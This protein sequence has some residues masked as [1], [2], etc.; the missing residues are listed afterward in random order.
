M[1]RDKVFK[2]IG[3]DR[4]NL[5]E[6]Q[7]KQLV[8]NNIVDVYGEIIKKGFRE[9]IKKVDIE[10]YFSP[11]NIAIRNEYRSNMDPNK[12]SQHIKDVVKDQDSQFRQG[13]H[14]NVLISEKCPYVLKFIKHN[15][16]ALRSAE[17][18]LQNYLIMKSV[19]G[20]EFFAKQTV[21]RL[22][23]SRRQVI[24]QEKLN[25]KE[26]SSLSA[27][28]EVFENLSNVAKQSENKAKLDRFLN[29]IQRLSNEHRLLVDALGDNIFY[30]INDEGNLNIKLIDYGC[31]D[32]KN[33]KNSSQTQSVEKFLNELR[34]L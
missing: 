9:T 13:Y 16:S 23:E 19:I 8:K 30:K 28:Q 22:K 17:N 10:S 34:K 20:E 26:W 29:G 4:K 14:W 27:Y 15:D 6:D 21:I 33:P 7:L 24:L 2:E 1:D 18:H 11:E 25:P 3:I 31:F 5:S 12:A 32:P